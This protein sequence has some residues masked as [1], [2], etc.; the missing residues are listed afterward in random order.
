MILHVINYGG[1]QT[2][3]NPR[4]RENP[5]KSFQNFKIFELN[6]MKIQLTADFA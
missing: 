5:W 1:E 2:I 4:S 6:F 3:L